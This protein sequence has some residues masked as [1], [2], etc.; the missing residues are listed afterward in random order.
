M[1][2]LERIILILL[3]GLWGVGTVWAGEEAQEKEEAVEEEAEKE[4]EEDEDKR[5]TFEEVV[6]DFDKIEGLFDL[7]RDPEENKVFLA[8]RPEQFEQ[9][10]LCNITRTQGDGYF[11]DSASLVSM[12]RGW[13]TFP[14]V[15]E[16]VGKKVFF[17]HKNVYY[18]AE[19]DAAIHRAVDR[20]L[21]DSI[22][23][24]GSIEGQ[25]HPETGA[26]LV[27][28]GG[29]F[30][31][32]I[33]LVSFIFSEFIK[34]VSYDF[35]GDN[36]YF[37]TLKNFPH[38]TEI[39]VVLH[40]KT[41]A[42]KMDIPTLADERSFQH[43]YHYSLSSLPESDFQPR[44]ADDRVGH[45]TTMYQDYTSVLTDDPYVRYVDRWH[46]EKAEPKFKRSPPK[47]PIVFWMENTIPVE[48][49]E[50]VREGILVWNKAFDRLGFENAVVVEQ[51]PDDAEWDAG[52]VRYS[53]I[54]WMVQPG[55]G[56]AVGPS[57]TNP[58]TGEI[59]D[60]DIRISA[61]FVRYAYLEF[62]EVVEPV[63]RRA[64][65]DSISA[66]IGLTGDYTR[67]F[68]DM[69]DGLVQEAAFGW[70]LLEA[71]A[72]AGGEV[73]E[74]E[75]IRQLM[76]EL[77]AHE[78]GHTL[79]LRHN[80]KASTLHGID[81]L[82][83]REITDKEG[84][85]SSVMDY[86]PVNIAPEGQQQGEYYQTTLG[87]YDY[88]AIEYAYR[89]V[90]ADSPE[91]ERAQLAKIAARVA[92]RDL[93][94][95]TDE[96]AI[97]WTRGIDPSAAR[98]DLRDDPIAHYRDQLDLSKELWDKVEEKFER[99]GE[100]YQTLRRV[101]GWGF[102]PYYSGVGNISRYIGGIHHYRDHIGDPKGRTPLQPVAPARQRQ[103]LEFLEQHVFGPEAFAWSPELLNKLAPE[104]WVDFT[105]SV[106]KVRRIDY[107]IHDIVLGIQ[108]Q[109][110]GRFYDPVLLSRLQDLEL[111]YEEGE[112]FT[113]VDLFTGL[114]QAIWAELEAGG[115]INSF[116]RNLQRAHL[117]K[118]IGLVVRPAPGTPEDARSLGRADLRLLAGRIEARLESGGLDTYSRAHLEE[119]QARIEAALDADL[120]WRL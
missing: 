57:R 63:G 106:F 3:L 65:G 88:W 119:T 24:V 97:Y 1:G 66:A 105:W 102:R 43:V 80:F 76:V 74:E 90:A 96:D 69:A 95:G 78:V 5:T 23:G 22:M 49:R 83:D 38:N 84:I 45:F 91:S 110:L 52:D 25:P 99:K 71:R 56:Y 59:F 115:N 53:T 29:F 16:R 33:A 64:V 93:A 109:P 35:D 2:A 14:F 19:E 82:H 21:S 89:P 87:P 30:I 27:D 98:W 44:L 50:A 42:P 94:Y 6:E 11:F 39:D 15:F 77:V 8:I 20:G 92:E 4:D 41:G 37:S 104:R 117:R 31:Q 72:A 54:R 18:R 73:D 51:Q 32:D 114:R 46:L 48:Y 58:F 36:S 28:P 108:G 62:T 79:G 17:A 118:L 26:V 60:A 116:R 12:G 9:I 67:G 75:F 100:R 61:D 101:F 113:M 55:Q 112:A 107:P 81:E 34:R 120:E 13:G 40:F 103:A 7:Y 86:N 111:R 47:K 70:H 68:C 85:S 10:Y